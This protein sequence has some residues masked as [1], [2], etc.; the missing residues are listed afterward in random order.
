MSTGSAAPRV[1]VVNDNQ[2]TRQLV[3]A[4]L[5]DEGYQVVAVADGDTALVMIAPHWWPDLILLGSSTAG[6]G[7]TTF[8]E[9]YHR[10]PGTHAPI[11]LLTDAPGVAAAEHAEALGAVGF[12]RQPIDGGALKTLARQYLPPQPVGE[13]EQA[14]D[15]QR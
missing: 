15:A 13:Q 9:A 8:V 2:T 10:L 12:L 7:G 14:S 4:L 11:I 6:V 5:Q 3:V 1:L